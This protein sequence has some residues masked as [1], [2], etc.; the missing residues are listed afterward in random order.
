MKITGLDKL[1]KQL[2]QAE[3]ACAQLDGE[4]CTVKFD[5]LDP[6]CIEV[7]IN[8]IWTAIDEKMIGYETNPF[9]KP[10]IEQ[11]KAKY[12][13]TIIEKAAEARLKG[14]AE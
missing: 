3:K 14:G 1:T 10:L 5:P 12:R 4:L 9:V 11:T 7:A 6:A 2:K 8:T 13:E